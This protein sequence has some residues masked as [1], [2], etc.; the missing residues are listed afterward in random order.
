MM[1]GAPDGHRGRGVG[2][3]A[4]PPPDLQ[5]APWASAGSWGAAPRQTS[6]LSSKHVRVG[7]FHFDF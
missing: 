5:A 1:S 3:P 7:Q 4:V 2:R 6:G